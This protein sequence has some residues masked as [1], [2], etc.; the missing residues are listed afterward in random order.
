MSAKAKP[1]TDVK[2]KTKPTGVTPLMQEIRN[3]SGVGRVAVSHDGTGFRAEVFRTEQAV[4]KEAKAR[5]KKHKGEPQAP[6][7]EVIEGTQAAVEREPIAF[8]TG[9]SAKAALKQALK[10]LA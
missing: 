5:V 7:L 3:R 10:S 8:G 2:G 6:I 9:K 4:I 1:K